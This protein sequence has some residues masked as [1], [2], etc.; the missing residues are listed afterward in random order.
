GRNRDIRRQGDW[1][2]LVIQNVKEKRHL[3]K[4]GKRIW[5]EMPTRATMGRETDPKKKTP[6]QGWKNCQ[7][8]RLMATS[9]GFLP[10]T[11]TLRSRRRPGG[12]RAGNQCCVW[13]RGGRMNGAGAS[14]ECG[15]GMG[16]R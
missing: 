7:P 10:T 1:T 3:M 11:L 6:T 13:C 12:W 14:G 8:M 5:F 4:V 9:T 16:G 2:L 15:E